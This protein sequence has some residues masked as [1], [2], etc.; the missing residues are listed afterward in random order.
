MDGEFLLRQV[1][2]NKRIAGFFILAILSIQCAG[3]APNQGKPEKTRNAEAEKNGT[4]YFPV[5]LG[6]CWKYSGQSAADGPPRQYSIENRVTSLQAN[7]KKGVDF[8]VESKSNTGFNKK[9]YYS[10]EAD[11][12]LLDQLG[13]EKYTPPKQFLPIHPTAKAI[14]WTWK[15]S[16]D[17]GGT[18]LRSEEQYTASLAHDSK[19]NKLLM[20]K[21]PKGTLT[22]QAGIGFV[23]QSYSYNDGSVGGWGSAEQ[24]LADYEIK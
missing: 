13:D 14:T 8:V 12:I 22:Y 16:W 10:K 20:V 15:G 1:A 6:S 17:R 11:W 2:M 19:G 18:V 24:N 7:A 9:Y 21:G 5:S 3:G 23:S 4:E